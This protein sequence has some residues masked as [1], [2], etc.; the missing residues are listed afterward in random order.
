MK[1]QITEWFKSLFSEQPKKDVINGCLTLIFKNNNT[2]Q[3]LYIFKQVQ[4]QF[5]NELMERFEHNKKESN[6]IDTY[7]NPR[8]HVN[9]IDAK[10]PIFEQ[11]IKK[12]FKDFVS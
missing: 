4:K 9:H 6:V 8:K 12:D 11:P 7:F 5:H 2:E 1:T 10:D 3:S